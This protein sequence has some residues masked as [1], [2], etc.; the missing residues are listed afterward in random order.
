MDGY[1]INIKDKVGHLF[2]FVSAGRL[3]GT[4]PTLVKAF[5]S[6][7]FFDKEEA[8]EFAAEQTEELGMG[9][10]VKV[11]SAIAYIDEPE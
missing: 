11:F 3:D 8:E 7:M 6:K 10:I 2:Y 9:K 4:A 5:Y 1:S